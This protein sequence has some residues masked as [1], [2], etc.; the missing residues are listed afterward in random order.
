MDTE[1]KI[2]RSNGYPT[3]SE[4]RFIDTKG[5]KEYWESAKKGFQHI[6]CNRKPLLFCRSQQAVG[7]DALR[8]DLLQLK[9]VF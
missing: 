6:G 3:R 2:D 4:I 8:F 7:E 5:R 1:T 9:Y